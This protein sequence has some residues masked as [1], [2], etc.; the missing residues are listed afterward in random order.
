MNQDLSAFVEATEVQTNV[1]CINVRGGGA[2][3]P[4][5]LNVTASTVF[6]DGDDR[7]DYFIQ[8]V[9]TDLDANPRGACDTLS[10]GLFGFVS[11]PTLTP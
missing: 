6:S 9:D 1:Q 4:V 2:I 10:G 5:F 3:T 8:V 11:W 7:V